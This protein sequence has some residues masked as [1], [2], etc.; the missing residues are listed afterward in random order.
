MISRFIQISLILAF[1]SLEFKRERS[2]AVDELTWMKKT[3]IILMSVTWSSTR[4]WPGFMTHLLLKSSR[5]WKEELLYK[6]Y[7]RWN[8]LVLC[9]L[10][11]CT[12][13]AIVLT[14]KYVNTT[15]SRLRSMETLSSCWAQCDYN[16][17]NPRYNS[18]VIDRHEINEQGCH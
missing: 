11:L 10:L 7:Q 3:L 9:I 6:S 15:C 12:T 1:S 16:R 2:T 14:V 17:S 18:D 4:N 5:T 13:T 8:F